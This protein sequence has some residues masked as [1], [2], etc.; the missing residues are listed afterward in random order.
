MQYSSFIEFIT[1][2]AFILT[3]LMTDNI[4]IIL[5]SFTIIVLV[6]GVTVGLNP[7]V[8]I[9][10]ALLGRQDISQLHKTLSAQIGGAVF[11]LLTYHF[12]IKTKIHPRHKLD[13]I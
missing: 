7:L 8:S 3:G 10:K 12:L 11:A 6:Y 1:T 4:I 2:F 9:P 13:Q 5:A